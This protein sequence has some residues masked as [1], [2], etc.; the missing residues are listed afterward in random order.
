[1]QRRVFGRTPSEHDRIGEVARL[2]LVEYA[3]RTCSLLRETAL[4]LQVRHPHDRNHI[5]V[6]VRLLFCILA[7]DKIL[8][9]R[10]VL[11][12]LLDLKFPPR[13]SGSSM[14]LTVIPRSCCCTK[15]G[16]G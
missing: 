4:S 14:L 1:M 10:K 2:A 11:S 5:P 16:L 15:P 6:I 8:L 3:I 7:P 13:C 9:A 12:V